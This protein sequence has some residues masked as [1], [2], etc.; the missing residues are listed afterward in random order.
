MVKQRNLL[1]DFKDVDMDDIKA[2]SRY[3]SKFGADYVVENLQWSKDRILA[4]CDA[5]LRGK[6]CEG[7]TEISGLEQGG[8]LVFQMMLEV[9]MYVDDSSLRS[10][11]ERIKTVRTIQ[12]ICRG[13]C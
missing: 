11:T 4:T 5:T 6:M 7:L 8:P 1:T 10:M 13:T 3:Y 12:Q 9:V 2:S